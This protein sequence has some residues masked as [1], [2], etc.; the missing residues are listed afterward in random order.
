MDDKG[1]AH[2]CFPATISTKYEQFARSSQQELQLRIV[3]LPEPWQSSAYQDRRQ[4]QSN[5]LLGLRF[6]PSPSVS[7]SP[8]LLA[9]LVH[10]HSPA[11]DLPSLAFLCAPF[12][13]PRAG[14]NPS[15]RLFEYQDEPRMR[16]AAQRQAS[17]ARSWT[18]LLQVVE[19]SSLEH[20]A[21]KALIF[22]VRSN[23]VTSRRT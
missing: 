19:G 12:A 15:P 2:L 8:T 4:S 7:E 6:S 20:G 23:S 14:A 18:L 10:L 5:I 22:K 1:R 13:G 16:A 21:K 11:L 17:E 9:Y 3:K